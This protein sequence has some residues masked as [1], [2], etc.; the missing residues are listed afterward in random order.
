M[1]RE[2]TRRIQEELDQANNRGKEIED[3]MKALEGRVQTR[4]PTLAELTLVTW[5]RVGDVSFTKV[6]F[7][8]PRENALDCV[9]SLELCSQ[10]NSSKWDYVGFDRR[11]IPSSMKQDE[12]YLVD[13]WIQGGIMGRWLAEHRSFFE[14]RAAQRADMPIWADRPKLTLKRKSPVALPEDADSRV[15]KR[16]LPS[17][18]RIEEIE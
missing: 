3:K 7:T 10:E 16:V 4:G 1:A 18:S 12:K 8:C 11:R 13:V 9:R 15:V 5:E 17:N 2:A 6:Y 14:T